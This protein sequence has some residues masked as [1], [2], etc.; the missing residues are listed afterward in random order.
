MWARQIEPQVKTE[1]R[2]ERASIQ[3][4]TVPD[5]FASAAYATNP[6]AEDAAIATRGRPR[7]SM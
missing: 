7:R 5:A 3:S 6:I 2:A 1:D 4:R